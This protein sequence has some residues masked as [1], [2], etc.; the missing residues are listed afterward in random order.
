[1]D[2]ITEITEKGVSALSFEHALREAI[3]KAL[4]KNAFED[5]SLFTISRRG[6]QQTDS[7]PTYF[8]EIK[9]VQGN[10]FIKTA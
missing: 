1:M 7:E 10:D 2:M 6:V 3:D 5:S 9:K 8:V 4:Q